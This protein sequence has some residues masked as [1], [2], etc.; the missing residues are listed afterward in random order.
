[1]GA[2]ALDTALT[3]GSS[4]ITDLSQISFSPDSERSG[5]LREIE[6]IERAIPN[7]LDLY[8]ALISQQAETTHNSGSTLQKRAELTIRLLDLWREK[9]IEK[10]A[11][12]NAKW[13]DYRNNRE[14]ITWAESH[15]KV[16]LHLSK[17]E[18]RHGRALTAGELRLALGHMSMQS[19]QVGE[20]TPAAASLTPPI[21]PNAPRVEARSQAQESNGLP[22]RE[23]GA[24]PAPGAVIDTPHSWH[25]KRSRTAAIVAAAGIVLLSLLSIFKGSKRE[26]IGERAD[27]LGPENAAPTTTELIGKP[28]EQKAAPKADLLLE[29]LTKRRSTHTVA[30]LH[31]TTQLF[32]PPLV[33]STLIAASADRSSADSL[34]AMLDTTGAE[35]Q[36]AEE[37]PPTSDQDNLTSAIAE[38]SSGS[39]DFSTLELRNAGRNG[40]TLLRD[41][42]SS[43]A[44]VV[45][46]ILPFRVGNNLLGGSLEVGAGVK[47]ERDSEPRAQLSWRLESGFNHAT[48]NGLELGAKFNAQ[49]WPELEQDRGVTRLV[50]QERASLSANAAQWF[51]EGWRGTA[52][53]EVEYRNSEVVPRGAQLG[54]QGYLRVVAQPQVPNDLV[55]EPFAATY[56]ERDL[57]GRYRQG[58]GFGTDMAA[59]HKDTYLDTRVGLQR[60]FDAPKFS[61][62]TR[63]TLS[64]QFTPSLR[65][66]LEYRCEPQSGSGFLEERTPILGSNGWRVGVRITK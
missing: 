8:R 23:A 54:V 18:K 66:F 55:F 10:G 49:R 5:R 57:S 35:L 7:A 60:N 36:T 32:T 2:L 56:L 13:M 45:S 3:P 17:I 39:A 21:T 37:S 43:A 28:F 24:D 26:A 48:S 30:T 58:Y 44:A 50:D 29:P 20:S 12:P 22:I 4:F 9:D 61:P 33:D 31:D 38:I 27:S 52:K 25:K 34:G 15:A 40:L 53:G 42:N 11:D 47:N 46:H 59:R 65:G 16:I 14:Q 64:Q 6:V 62:L 63:A 1:M 51:S 19:E 41:Q